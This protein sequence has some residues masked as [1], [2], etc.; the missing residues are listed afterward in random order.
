M[1]ILEKDLINVQSVTSH[2][3]RHVICRF[4]NEFTPEKDPIN[5]QNVTN[6]LLVR[7]I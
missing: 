2:S 5:A 3:L 4:I 6:H 1:F 7:V